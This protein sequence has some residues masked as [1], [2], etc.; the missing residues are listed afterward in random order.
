MLQLLDW[1]L[2]LASFKGLR[3]LQ[4]F[5]LVYKFLKIVDKKII[6]YYQ[7]YSFNSPTVESER[8]DEWEWKV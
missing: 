8:F 5:K 1:A 3:H 2:S 6:G 7:V 4:M